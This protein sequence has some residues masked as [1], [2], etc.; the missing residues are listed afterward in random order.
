MR[1]GIGGIF[2]ETNTFASRTDAGAFQ[3]LRGDEIVRFAEGARTYLGG[4]LDGLREAGFEAA[5]LLYAEATPSGIIERKAYEALRDELIDSAALTPLDGI[6]LSLHGAGV[7]DGIDSIEEDI[8]ERVRARF[9]HE[10]PV[11]ATLDLHGNIRPHL[12]DLCSAL[13]PVRLNP[14]TDQHER[15][16][17][18]AVALRQILLEGARFETAIEPVPLLFPPVPTA[19]PTLAELNV[20]CEELESDPNIACVRV[21][22]GFPYADIPHLGASVVAVVRQGQANAAEVARRVASRLWRQ[23]SLIKVES[24]AADVAVREALS[25]GLNFVVINEFSD[26]TGAGTPGDGTHLLNALIDAKA[27]A[28]FSHIF[29]PETVIQAGK[30]GIGSVIEVCLGGKTNPIH[31]NPI[32]A[33]ARVLS[34][35]SGLYRVKSPMGTGETIDLGALATLRIGTIDVIVSSGRRQ[36]LDD[37]PFIKAAIDISDYRIVALKSSQHFRAWF[38]ERAARIITADPPGLSPVDVRLLNRARLSRQLWPLA[39][40]ASYAAETQL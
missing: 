29:D 5:P 16:L 21:M 22:H 7:A 36:T 3:Q 25:T 26:N 23:R 15:G 17:E 9:G 11:F 38:G 2:H 13:F 4:M 39:P 27:H 12:G 40:D 8:L 24:F 14:H 28:C 30:A 37:G 32:K 20:F 18:A 35:G 1:I 34:L 31:G 10:M 19:L 6:L 33:Q